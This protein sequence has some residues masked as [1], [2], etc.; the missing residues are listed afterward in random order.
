VAQSDHGSDIQKLAELMKGI[1]FAMLT[2]VEEDGTLHSRPMTTQDT[3]FDGDLCFLRAA[4]RP[5]CMNP[6]FTT[7]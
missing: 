5:K 2:T 7:R 4:M 1:R 3:E 6:I